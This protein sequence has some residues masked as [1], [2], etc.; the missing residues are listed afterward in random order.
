MSTFT[1]S[2]TTTVPAVLPDGDPEQTPAQRA[3]YRFFGARPEGVNVYM[4]KAGSTSAL[5]YGR[6]TENDPVAQYDSSGTLTSD[7]WEDIELV[8]WGG[9]GAVTVTSDQATAL[10]AA[11]YTVT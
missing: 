4:Y 8:F 5:A 11:G 9:H 3:L 6:V 1:P 10:T 2:A 7:G